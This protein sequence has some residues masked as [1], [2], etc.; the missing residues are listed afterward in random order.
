VNAKSRFVD[1]L[2]WVGE[3]CL[4][5]VAVVMLMP[6]YALLAL[7]VLVT[8]GLPVLYRQQRIGRAG[9][10]FVLY[11]FRSM[12]SGSGGR[13]ITID[14]DRR[15]T[16][17]GRFLR[18]TKLDEL[19]QLIN[20]LKGDMSFVGYRPEVEKYVK[21]RWDLYSLL[22][23]NRPGLT[24]LS[25]L[26]F[27]NEERLLKVQSDPDRYYVEEILPQKV[28]LSLQHARRQSLVFDLWI[29]VLTLFRVAGLDVQSKLRS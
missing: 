23:V 3:R 1:C 22:L 19:P 7:G 15:I 12:I 9:V 29:V 5:I 6:V 20:V 24:D 2:G 21:E 17:F 8:M 25:S 16:A 13:L 11:K 10:P 14:G 27:S 28:R 4:A 26:L 18:R